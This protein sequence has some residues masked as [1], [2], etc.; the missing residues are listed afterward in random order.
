MGNLCA[1]TTD[2]STLNAGCLSCTI[3]HSAF[4]CKKAN[5]EETETL[6]ELAKRIAALEKNKDEITNVEV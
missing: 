1:C 4:N 3:K 6:E 2:E 5:E